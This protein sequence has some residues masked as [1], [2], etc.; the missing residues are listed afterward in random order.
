[1]T[2][3]NRHSFLL[4]EL[5]LRVSWGADAVARLAHSQHTIGCGRVFT[6]VVDAVGFD[7]GVAAFRLFAIDNGVGVVAEESF[8][9]GILEEEGVTC[10]TQILATYCRKDW[11]SIIL[12]PRA[13]Q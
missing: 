2:A 11:V 3:Q 5:N 9:L 6:G 1:M 10:T 13:C 8:T 4:L 7:I 12:Y